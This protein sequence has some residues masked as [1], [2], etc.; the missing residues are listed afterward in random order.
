MKSLLIVVVSTLLW[1]RV[2]YSTKSKIKRLNF[3]PFLIKYEMC[4]L[5]R[6]IWNSKYNKVSTIFLFYLEVTQTYHVNGSFLLEKDKLSYDLT[7]YRSCHGPSIII[8]YSQI[9]FLLYNEK[10]ND[11]SW[12][13]NRLKMMKTDYR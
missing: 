8:G 7:R 10:V 5:N 12:E 9:Q 6:V 4:K 3:S 2:H 13:K 11:K 1:L